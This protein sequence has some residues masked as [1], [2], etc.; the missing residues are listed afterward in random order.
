MK[1]RRKIHKQPMDTTGRAF[2]RRLIRHGRER[3]DDRVFI[4][5]LYL[6]IYTRAGPRS[7]ALRT[8]RLHGSWSL[9]MLYRAGG[10]A[11]GQAVR[12][13]RRPATYALLCSAILPLT[14]GW[15]ITRRWRSWGWEQWDE[16]GTVRAAGAVFF[17]P[18]YIFANLFRELR[19]GAPDEGRGLLELL[20]GATHTLFLP[21]P[22][23][24]LFFV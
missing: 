14:D 1:I 17:F 18:L 4:C 20:D 13:A 10:Q 8:Q 2:T 19:G 15:D 5:P 9:G 11:G 22:P 7:F 23:S 3:K 16:H 12:Q 21:F 6:S 24:F